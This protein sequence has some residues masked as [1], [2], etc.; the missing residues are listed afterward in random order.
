MEAFLEG[1]G[2]WIESVVSCPRGEALTFEFDFPFR[3]IV[4]EQI[5]DGMALDR[6]CLGVATIR[7]VRSEANGVAR[8]AD[9]RSLGFGSTTPAGDRPSGVCRRGWR[10]GTM[11]ALLLKVI[12]TGLLMAALPATAATCAPKTEEI[13]DAQNRLVGTMRTQADCTLEAR[14]RVGW[15]LGRYSPRSRETR[16]VGGRLVSR[17]NTLAALVWNADKGTYSR[18]FMSKCRYCNSTSYGS[19]CLRSPHRQHEHVGDE[20]CCEFCGASSY[21]SGCLNSPTKRHR[22]GSGSGKCR[23]CGST[24]TGSGC[25]NSPT[26]NHEK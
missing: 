7:T 25:L 15:F 24:A 18:P 23:W 6:Q 3:H 21:G 11:V 2:T 13:R 20:K 22:H 8:R 14:D 19:G 12:V 5:M 16:D 4:V 26:R 9:G 17:G 10:R 1:H